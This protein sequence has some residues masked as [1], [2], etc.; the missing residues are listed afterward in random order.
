MH[1][2]FPFKEQWDGTQL[3]ILSWD[4][5]MK[6]VHQKAI[7]HWLQAPREPFILP[8]EEPIKSVETQ[9]A[10]QLWNKQMNNHPLSTDH[11][12]V[13]K[14]LAT[15][16]VQN[17]VLKDDAV[18]EDFKRQLLSRDGILEL[19]LTARSQK[20]HILC[21]CQYRCPVCKIFNYK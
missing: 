10:V 1:S 8:M 14:K 15:V 17:G 3:M 16:I 7:K 11:S 6:N 2:Q 21:F 19:D 13:Y 9:S 12:I 18:L 5:S 20:R 4:E